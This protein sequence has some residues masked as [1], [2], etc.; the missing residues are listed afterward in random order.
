[1]KLFLLRT[2]LI[3]LIFG[4][5]VRSHKKFRRQAM[6]DRQGIVSQSHKFCFGILQKF[7]F[8]CSVTYHRFILSIEILLTKLHEAELRER[9]ENLKRYQF[10]K[11]NNYY[12]NYSIIQQLIKLSNNKNRTSPL[13]PTERFKI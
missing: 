7:F 9:F 2:L 3:L 1:M 12:N 5:G 8:L 4:F 6:R 13:A 11:Q 10:H